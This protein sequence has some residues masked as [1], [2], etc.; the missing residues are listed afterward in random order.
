MS[1]YGDDI[2]RA[3][4]R[5]DLELALRS[6][7]ELER[8]TVLAWLKGATQQEIAD[9]QGVTQPVICERLSIALRKLLAEMHNG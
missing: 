4:L 1:N 2:D 7:T 5:L 6:L 3:D 9:M 8:Q